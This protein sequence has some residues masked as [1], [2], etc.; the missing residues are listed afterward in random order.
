M[1]TNEMNGVVTSAMA[2]CRK[3]AQAY[4]PYF[5]QMLFTVAT[6]NPDL[7]W[8]EDCIANKQ[9]L[10]NEVKAFVIKAID[11][12]GIKFLE[13]DLD[14]Y[15]KIVL[16]PDSNDPNL[17]FPAAI[18]EFP[19][20]TRENVL[21]CIDRLNKAN[22]KPMFFSAQ[23]LPLLIEIVRSANQSALTTYE[24]MSRKMARLAQ[25]VREMM[26]VTDKMKSDY[27]RQCGIEDTT[28]VHVQV[29]VEEK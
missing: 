22:S 4:G 11:I 23:D 29:N 10:R 5:G 24:E 8:K 28:T 6:T 18:P 3:A 13:K 27:L 21:E 15:P 19:K 17:V 20:A 9:T 12:C 14:G 7:K 1:N 2:Q 16:N 25:T 26:D